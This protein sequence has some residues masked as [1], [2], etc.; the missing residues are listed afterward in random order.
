MPS[1][2]TSISIANKLHRLQLKKP[3]LVLADKLQR[4]LQLKLKLDICQLI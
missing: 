1:E 3:P 4:L 2:K